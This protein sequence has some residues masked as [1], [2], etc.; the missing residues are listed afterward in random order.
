[1]PKPKIGARMIGQF[2]KDPAK[3]I[4][5]VIDNYGP[6]VQDQI[7]A[8]LND[9]KENLLQDEEKDLA[10]LLVPDGE[11]INALVVAID[12]TGNPSRVIIKSPLLDIIKL[13]SSQINNKDIQIENL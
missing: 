6:E 3:L 9:K 10:L 8:F 5:S 7:L 12:I 1:M 13:L 2:L 11:H 4:N